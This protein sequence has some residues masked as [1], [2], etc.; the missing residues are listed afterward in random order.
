MNNTDAVSAFVALGQESRLNMF[1]LIVQKGDTGLTPTQIHE[2]LGIPNATLSFHLKELLQASLITQERQSRNLIYR[3]NALHANALIE[4]LME[5]CCDGKSCLP[6]ILPKKVENPMK[7]YNILFL[8]TH[9]SARSILGEAL[10]STHLSGLFVGYSAGSQP[11]KEVNPFA[12]EIAHDLG[13]DTQTL[14][15]KS[16]DEFAKLDAPKMD[17]IITVCDDAAGEICPVWPGNPAT[18][19]W[20]FADPSEITGSDEEKRQVFKDIMTG[21]K[22]RIDYLAS[23]PLEKLDAL[24]TQS[25][26]KRLAKI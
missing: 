24:S 15:P 5:N 22:K 16:W 13:F 4:F 20:G 10:A 9:N 26:L 21:L 14:H 8:C 6:E 1:R 19:H 18:A 2:M 7:P 11:S 17:F 25:E 12:L 23:L 3:P